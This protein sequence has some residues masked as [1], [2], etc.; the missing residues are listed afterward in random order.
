MERLVEFDHGAATFL[1]TPLA[2]V[3]SQIE[4]SVPATSAERV[5]PYKLIREI[6][7]GGMGAVYEGE[8]SDGELTLRVA[9]KFVSRAIRSDFVVERFKRER[10]I[11]ANLNH[12]N[13]CRLI[14][15][16]TAEDGSPYL[17]MELIE[18]E[19][20][21]VWSRGRS[22]RTVCTLFR[23]VCDAVQHAHQNLIVHRD[24]KPG[25]ILVTPAGQPKLL[26]F[27][28]AKI[29]DTT[30]VNL[31]N[32]LRALTPDYASP[33]QVAGLPITAATDIYGLACVLYHLL[34]GKPPRRRPG[35]DMP[36]PASSFAPALDGDLDAI[37][38]R[39]MQP[40]PTARF[41]TAREFG[42]ELGRW[43]AYEPVKAVDGGWAYVARLF[44]RRNR[45]IAA[46]MAAVTLLLTA[47]T[48]YAWWRAA[49]AGRQVQSL[50]Q[51]VNETNLAISVAPDARAMAD[52][53]KR[54]WRS[55]QQAGI[56]DAD[57]AL[58]VAEVLR[59][60]GDDA[61][62]AKMLAEVDH[63]TDGALLTRLLTAQ[64]TL[65]LDQ[66]HLGEAA[67]FATLSLA[68]AEQV[69]S[70]HPAIA[71]AAATQ[72]SRV[73]RHLGQLSQA[74]Q[75]V[76]RAIGWLT[77]SPGLSAE[78]DRQLAAA[79][80]QMAHILEDSGDL[81]QALKVQQ[82]A[83]ERQPQNL[84]MQ[85]R[86]GELLEASGERDR[87][88][89]QYKSI[90]NRRI[91]G[92]LASPAGRAEWLNDNFR[93]AMALRS[94]GGSEIEAVNLLREASREAKRLAGEF[95]EDRRVQIAR[96]RILTVWQG[97]GPAGRLNADAEYLRMLDRSPADAEVLREF[98]ANR[99]ALVRVLPQDQ[100]APSCSDGLNRLKATPHP[101]VALLARQ[102]QQ[103]CSAR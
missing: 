3:A 93:Y 72:E 59:S 84:T 91:A 71:A 34:T 74:R 29:L 37:L 50:S 90:I 58:A 8:R 26:D 9:V 67:Q 100:I 75:A 39:A 15:A 79:F 40:E 55:R 36:P 51:I 30:P 85:R 94:T 99:I 77:G 17:V 63:R 18:G 13:I 35:Q 45:W 88:R 24:L 76:E 31:Q 66:G 60:C 83:V 14:D 102:L 69:A 64:S 7:R 11:L 22:A 6:G 103:I 62:A 48:G 81:T 98:A 65:A 80:H 12:P 78:R 95:P 20:I 23:H 38:A 21:D 41:A 54:Q 25:N 28:I 57:S 44:V 61:G 32:T 52:A 92:L 2:S 96:A 47:G 56:A 101:A 68:L 73:D 42:E 33:E 70:D 82:L 86:V 87:A 4:Q 97:D 16:G 53:V 46:S 19:T 5:G 1:G 89:Q 27:G 49:R 43:V 10:Q